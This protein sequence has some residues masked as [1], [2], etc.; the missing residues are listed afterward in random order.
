MKTNTAYAHLIWSSYFEFSDEVKEDLIDRAG[1]GLSDSTLYDMACEE[2][3]WLLDDEKENLKGTAPANGIFA[4]ARLG[5]WNG[6]PI[7]VLSERLAD[8]LVTAGD[9][10]RSYVD[11][12]S[13]ITAYVD[14][15]GDFRIN[16]AHHDGTNCY[17]FRAWKQDVTEGEKDEVRSAVYYGEP[18]AANLIAKYTDRMGD[19]I[20][21]VYGWE[22]PA[23]VAPVI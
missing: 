6:S 8:R 1:E 17:L 5:L 10:I 20:G 4:V 12:V 16:E 13:D 7:A 21:Q 9:C 19:A 3:D 2:N 14:E 11:G 23:P 15:Y 22:F 18:N